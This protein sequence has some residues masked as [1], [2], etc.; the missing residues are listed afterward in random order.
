MMKVRFQL[1]DIFKFYF[2]LCTEVVRSF[3]EIFPAQSPPPLTPPLCLLV[4]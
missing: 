4:Q 3:I 2:T 1:E